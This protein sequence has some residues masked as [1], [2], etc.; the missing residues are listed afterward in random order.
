L[1]SIARESFHV[2]PSGAT[3]TARSPAPVLRDAYTSRLEVNM[4]RL[5][6]VFAVLAALSFWPGSS[7]GA[8]AQDPSTPAATPQQEFEHQHPAKEAESDPHQ[9]QMPQPM[10]A[11]MK[12]AEARLDALLKDMNAA[13]GEA[14]MAA[15]AAVV[16]ELARQHKG[17]SGRTCP[18]CD[19]M[20]REGGMKPCR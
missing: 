15:V 12:S 14:K 10:R 13:T 19:R 20:M 8:A 7:L 11:E 1:G 6:L 5:A 17:M 4:T 18:M 16:N 2:G 9:V 3:A